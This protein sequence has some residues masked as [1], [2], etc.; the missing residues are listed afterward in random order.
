[1]ATEKI[2]YKIDVEGNAK[3]QLDNAKQSIDKFNQSMRVT[4]EDGRRIKTDLNAMKN[5]LVG[6]SIAG[7]KGSSTYQFLAKEAAI[8]EDAN[9]RVTQEVRFHANSY[10][11]LEAGI[12][13]VQGIG[14]AFQ[15]AN[16]IVNLFGIENEKVTQSIRRM[17]AIQQTMNGVQQMANML[18]KEYNVGLLLETTRTKALILTQKLYTAAVVKTT[19]ALKMFRIALLSTGVL[20]LV[21]GI[22]ML[23]S[24]FVKW[25]QR[26]KEQT[27]AEQ[28]HIDKLKELQQINDDRL[29]D[30]A[31]LTKQNED[32]GKSQRQLNQE[33]LES[34]RI[35]KA[36]QKVDV[37]AAQQFVENAQ[38]ALDKAKGDVAKSEAAQANAFNAPASVQK[39]LA[40]RV[41]TAKGSLDNAQNVLDSAKAKL[42]VESTTLSI[43]E[44]QA[45]ASKNADTTIKNRETQRLVNQ[46]PKTFNVYINE[47]GNIDNVNLIS[48]DDEETFRSNLIRT[49]TGALQTI[50][51]QNT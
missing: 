5:E 11:K 26:V 1:M 41:E 23:I 48:E 9:R 22:G 2:T 12:K 37:D 30:L 16:G 25:R 50:Q 51:L 42:A 29:K 18:K 40:E 44:Q 14:G 8:L 35:A 15:A 33:K 6:L 47:L 27:A 7:Q 19:G 36:Q 4:S 43:L 49:L 17:M 31:A 24:A 34:I 45:K 20:A 38:N 32:Y 39:S 10:K 3:Q 13:M 46:A 21:A 28:E